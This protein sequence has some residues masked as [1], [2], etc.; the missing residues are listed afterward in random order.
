MKL[1]IITLLLLGSTSAFAESQSL[2]SCAYDATTLALE[3]GN[4]TLTKDQIEQKILNVVE[5][6]CLIS[7]YTT[8]RD[9]ANNPYIFNGIKR[10][11]IEYKISH[12]N[13]GDIHQMISSSL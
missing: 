13:Q 6:E 2:E 10:A 8:I 11:I 1:F 5:R 3:A 9:Q 12:K 4:A 7:E